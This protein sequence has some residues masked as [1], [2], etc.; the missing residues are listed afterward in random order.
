M[1]WIRAL[2]AA[3]T[4]AAVTASVAV[5]ATGVAGDDL[6]TLWHNLAPESVNLVQAV[7]QRYL[8]PL[9]WTHVLVPVLLT[10]SLVVF[11]VLGSVA[12]LL[13]L[14]AWRFAGTG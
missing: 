2:L 10:P 11:A 8:H 13:W 12:L 5:V 1:R 4:I 6:G 3:V 7:V 9:L 14:L